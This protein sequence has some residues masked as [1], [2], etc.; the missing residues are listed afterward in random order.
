[1]IVEKIKEFLDKEW[2][3]NISIILFYLIF[4]GS[5]TLKSLYV[6]FSININKI[7]VITDVNGNMMIALFFTVLIICGLGIIF[8][9]NKSRIFIIVIDVI[10]TLIF[11]A[12]L[13][14]GRYYYNPI[15]IPILKQ[16]SFMDD[17]KNSTASLF[18]INDLL[19]FIDFF[20]LIVL[21]FYLRKEKRK[22]PFY[23]QMAIGLI[24]VVIG[25]LGTQ[26]KY[27]QIDASRFVYERKYVGRDLGL[28]YYHYF[29]IKS[30][31]DKTLSKK[32]KLT[33]EEIAIIE[34]VNNSNKMLP[35]QYSNIGEGKN[36]IVIQLEALQEF[37]VDLEVEGQKVMPFLNSLKSN[38]IYAPNYYIQT[39]GGNTV[40][41]ELLTNTSLHPTY[42]GSAYYE[43]PSNTYITMPIKLKEKGYNVY[44]FHGYEASFWNR[45]VMH[46]T[47]GFDKFYSLNDF[48][49]EEKVGWAISDRTFLKQSLDYTLE[50]SEGNPFYSFMITLSSH[51]PYDAFYSGPFT[52]NNDNG[53][54]KRYFNAANYV[55]SALEEF[56][57]YMKEKDMYE[58]SIIVIY[59]DHAGLFNND[60]KATTSYFGVDHNPY[61]W[62]KFEK[63]PLL[64]HN[65][66][67]K[68]VHVEKVC[69]QI[70]L[71]P[72]LANIMGFNLEYTM[73]HD[74][75]SPKYEGHI[76][77]RQSNVITNDYI[78]ISGEEKIYDYE[79]G[80]ELDLNLY[81]EELDSYFDQLR[82]I[83]LIY[84]SDYLKV[85]NKE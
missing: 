19:L 16:I 26:Y 84:K 51:H 33:D 29:D 76:V 72:T 32:T 2:V 50:N 78:Y 58:N 64:I 65:P 12:D 13:L 81:K 75:M 9:G 10:L 25:V 38:S 44:S 79:T 36:L 66:S 28:I 1:M 80:I 23:M 73:G 30:A 61:T 47:L 17:V 31:V 40:D 48:D 18:R 8:F 21:A 46:K 57:A 11:F 55:D 4:I 53:M 39:A 41:A 15:T 6:Q 69:G 62:Q 68:P 70:D 49:V 71:L 63:I 3:K 37:L 14:Y 56:F 54:L 82:A 5:I 60:A 43:Y 85:Y 24:V 83:D 34:S 42:G 67:I 22:K 7:P 27:N 35:N 20:I 77:R 45:E 59:G 74:I 52:K